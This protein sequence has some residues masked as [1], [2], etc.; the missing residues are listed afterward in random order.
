M[1][2]LRLIIFDVD[3]TLV[4]SQ[5]E[6]VAAMDHAHRD[7]GFAMPSRGAILSIVGLSLPE[8]FAVLH[9]GAS[10]PDREALS[11]GYKEAY[12]HLRTAGEGTEAPLFA[13]AVETLEMLNAHPETLL[14]V[15]TGKSRRG[16]DRLLMHHG[17]ERYFVTTQVSDNHPSKPAPSMIL[18]AMQEA[19]VEAHQTAMVGDTTY[20]MQM[21]R[22]AGVR[23]IG[24]SWGYHAAETLDADVVLGQMSDLI[25]YLDAEP[26]Q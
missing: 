23:A 7:S 3:G 1:S 18:Q 16:L 13:G 6:I 17:L 5:A 9:P 20:D 25:P 24:V 14:G 21:A 10:E 15:A 2:E 11:A 8:A 22:A 4:D 19:G 26:L 12:R